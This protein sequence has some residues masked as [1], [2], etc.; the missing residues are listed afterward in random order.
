VPR[1]WR[2]AD[3]VP[4]HTEKRIVPYTPEQMFDL[5][6]G[7]ERY[8]EFLPWCLAARVRSRDGNV[9]VADLVIGF[10]M[11]RERYT[12]RVV[13][14]RPRQIDVEY[15]EGPLKHLNNHWVFT[16]HESGGTTVDFSVDFE[17]RSRLLQSLIGVL[18]HEALRRL[19]AAFEERARRLYG[20]LAA[21]T[22][23]SPSRG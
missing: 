11:V 7:V 15:L 5:V 4:A 3:F 2:R 14:D 6:A 8:P 16:P 17:F 10:K 18:F 1:S 12:S 20:P 21:A 13:L 9:L 19:V 23:P 22:A